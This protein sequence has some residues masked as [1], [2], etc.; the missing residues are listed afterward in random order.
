MK[1]KRGNKVEFSEIVLNEISK[2]A[3]RIKDELTLLGETQR[4]LRFVRGS[5]DLCRIHKDISNIPDNCE[6]EKI[7]CFGGQDDGN[8]HAGIC[9]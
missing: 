8:R 4:L 2:A 3:S 5:G 6:P 7:N 1:K 9:Y